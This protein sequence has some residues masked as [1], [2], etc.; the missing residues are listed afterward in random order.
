MD[1]EAYFAPIKLPAM[2]CSSLR[3]VE[4]DGRGFPG[5]PA[6]YRIAGYVEDVE[7]L[8]CHLDVDRLMLYG[9][10][11]GGTVAL[12]YA[13]VYP[14]RVAR[15]VISNAAARVDASFEEAVAEARRR[16]AETVP[17]AVE[18]L[19]AADEADAALDRELSTAES[20]RAFR[21]AMVC[22]VA[23][24]GPAE[25]AYLDRLCSAPTNDEAA[26][27]MYAEMLE[28]LDLLERADAV[29]APALVIAGESDVV[30]PPAA[31]RLI[32]DSL[33]NARY[34]EFAGVGHFRW[35]RGQRPVPRNGVRVPQPTAP[36]GG[37]ARAR[38]APPLCQRPARRSPS[39]NQ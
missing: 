31:A 16:F 14:E 32:A 22:S 36:A 19:A 6:G 25:T 34:I 1:P 20:Q 23:R 30:V 12:A 33:P 11:H 28:G 17:D 29:T 13:C 26:G 27:A 21:T 39:R 3:L 7:S 24:E 37:P 2:K 18:R 15:L 35:G 10:S 4:Q 38:R 8:R 9:N 5:S